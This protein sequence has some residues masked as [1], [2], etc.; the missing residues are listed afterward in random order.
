M[1]PAPLPSSQDADEIESVLGA[2]RA[3][4]THPD[5]LV[6]LL[7]M[8]APAVQRCLL[9]LTLRGELTVDPTG[10]ITSGAGA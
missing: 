3:G 1:T 9:I 7:G 4:A 2:V 10:R 5:D 6:S 8:P